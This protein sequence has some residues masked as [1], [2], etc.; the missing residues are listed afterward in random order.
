MVSHQRLSHGPRRDAPDSDR[1]RD[2]DVDESEG[3]TRCGREDCAYTGYPAAMASH[4]RLS[5]GPRRAAPDA[6]V[7]ALLERDRGAAAV[8]RDICEVMELDEDD[9]DDAVE[10]PDVNLYPLIAKLRTDR[11]RVHLLLAEEQQRREAAEAALRTD[12]WHVR[13]HSAICDAVALLGA[14]SIEPGLMYAARDRLRQALIDYADAVLTPAASA[15]PDRGG[16]A[17]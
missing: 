3:V 4:R 10:Y 1:A 8:V 11:E 9:T 6:N 7:K 14:A 15:D 2:A 17:A 13:L 12:V 5:H 16:T